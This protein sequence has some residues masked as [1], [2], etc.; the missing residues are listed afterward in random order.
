LEVILSISAWCNFIFERLL[1][2][3][4]FIP[5]AILL[6]F[7]VFNRK[8]YRNANTKL[9]RFILTALVFSLTARYMLFINLGMKI[10]TRYLYTTAFYV[11]ILCVP[12]FTLIIHFLKYLTKKFSW[13]K[14]KHLTV[15]LLLVIGIACIGKA[16]HPPHK[17]LYIQGVAKIIKASVPSAPPIL[18]SNV[19]DAKR[20]AWHSNAELLILSSVT[21]IDNPVF[22]ENVLKA[23]SSK[24]KNV[25]L[26]VQFKDD[27]FRKHFSN[28]KVRFPAKLI[29]MKEFKVKHKTFYSLYKIGISEKNERE[30]GFKPDYDL[31]RALPEIIRQQEKKS[32]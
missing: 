4:I 32:C 30:L 31:E 5:V 21:N 8:E 23:L 16:L 15:F 9:L 19:K 10:N 14:E 22:F 11:I 25:F 6:V 28:K 18:I 2:D 1:L 27:E 13:I 12:G 29:L 26:F 7:A 24:N 3:A 20:V 17:K